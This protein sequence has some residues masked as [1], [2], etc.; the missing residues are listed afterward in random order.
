MATCT[1][2][3]Y[4]TRIK[5]VGPCV[6]QGPLRS[7][8]ITTISVMPSRSDFFLPWSAGQL[9]LESESMSQFHREL[10]WLTARGRSND[11]DVCEDDGED[12]GDD[13]NGGGDCGSNDSCNSG[14]ND[15]NNDD[16]DSI[17]EASA[18]RMVVP[19]DGDKDGQDKD[20]QGQESTEV[21]SMKNKL[22][23]KVHSTKVPIPLLF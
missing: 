7:V 3:Y 12:D 22:V 10:V 4:I 16:Q 15:C 11:S 20:V 14:D 19:D 8:M 6:G 17:G 21:H 13:D 18:L 1:I 9:A 2:L 23:T 5:L